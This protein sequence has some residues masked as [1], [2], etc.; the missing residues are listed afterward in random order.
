[1]HV[2]LTVIGIGWVVFWVG[3]FLAGLTAKSSQRGGWSRLAGLRGVSAIVVIILIRVTMSGH[4]AIT[5]PLLDGIGLAVW[6]LGLALAIWA[7]FY[8]GRNWGMPMT[9][10]EEPDLVTTGPY[11]LIRHPIYTG[12]IVAVAGTALATSLYGLIGVAVLLAYFAYSARTEERFLTERFPDTF[13][14]YKARTKMLIPF[15]V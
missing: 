5:S 2:I 12:I 15:V 10:R 9:R 13:P 11:R 3:W 7:R 6:A 4:R 1:M 8:L 14:P